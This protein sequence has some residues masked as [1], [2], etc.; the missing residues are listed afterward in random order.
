MSKKEPELNNIFD[1]KPRLT[2]GMELAASFALTYY[3]MMFLYY[4][5]AAVFYRYSIDFYYLGKQS[6][7]QN[8]YI[9]ILVLGAGLLLSSIL[10]LSLILI[11]C[12]KTYW[13]A[14]FVI[15]SLILIV[16]QLFTT[17]FHPWLKYA[18]E[19]LMV[20]VI[21]PIRIKKIR[22][23]VVNADNDHDT[24]NDDDDDSDTD[25]DQIVDESSCPEV[26]CPESSNQSN[27]DDSDTDNDKDHD[28]EKS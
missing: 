27:D 13:K 15:T 1:L 19:V 6:V 3:V 11:L 20:L 14:V 2:F 18:I 17:S 26:T 21:T 12:K 23:V 25:N 10:V 28:N 7:Y 24:D 9:D 4:V 22:K 8:K 16:Y 5:L